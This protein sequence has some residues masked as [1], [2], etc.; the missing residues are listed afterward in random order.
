MQASS[1]YG[2]G[3][4]IAHVVK[5]GTTF[6]ATQSK[7][8][9]GNAYQ[10]HWSTAVAHEAFL[11]TIPAPSSSQGRLACL[12]LA[13]GT[14]RWSQ[15]TVGSGPIGYGS[16]IKAANALIVLTEGGELVLVQPNPDAYTE[17][18]RKKILNLWSWNHVALS[19]GRIYARNSSLNSEIVALEVSSGVAPLP[20][21][22]LTAAHGNQTGTIQISIRAMDGTALDTSHSLRMELV[23][24]TEITASQWLVWDQSLTANNGSLIAEFPKT[25]QQALFIRAREKA[26]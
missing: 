23:T 1:A 25:N 12:D 24:A 15:T 16:I 17:I 26:N 19:N 6:T 2:S 18:A 22:A 20:P 8:Q 10:L 7:R 11:Y 14:N 9:Q 3:T 13:A 4:Y 21:L 5:D